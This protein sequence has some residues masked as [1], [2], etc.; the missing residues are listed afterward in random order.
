MISV[1][2]SMGVAGVMK[3]DLLLAGGM[4]VRGSV[5]DWGISLAETSLCCIHG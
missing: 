5:W 1:S 4:Q 2:I 3:K